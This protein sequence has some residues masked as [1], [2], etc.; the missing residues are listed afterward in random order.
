[1]LGLDA[2]VNV[3]N[4]VYLFSY[5]VRD[6]LYL[7][8]LT[9]FGA[10][11]LLPYYYLQVEPLYAP[12]AWNVV[13]ISI[14]IYWIIRLIL[15]RRPVQFS[16]EER[17]L[18]QLALRN[19]S[20]RDAFKLFR[21]GRWTSA[22]AGTSPLTQG[23]PVDALSLISKGRVAVEMNGKRVDTIGE[24]CFLG[25]HAFLSGEKDF[26]APVTVRAIE[27]TRIFVWPQAELKAQFAKNPNLQI[28]LEASLG[29]E[30]ARYLQTARTQLLQLH[31]T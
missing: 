24:G 21:L 8:I 5:S 12:M 25:A 20:E 6:I 30:I 14:N 7:R 27:P 16:D 19:M 28:A 9:V 10:A 18:Y 1:M 2:L 15:E 29:M 31:M 4:V 3:A 23:V 17:R 11:L 22:Q 13:F 26:K